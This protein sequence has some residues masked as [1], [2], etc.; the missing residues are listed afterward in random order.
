MKINYK[1]LFPL[2]IF[3]IIALNSTSNSNLR[4]AVLVT[5]FVASIIL[6]LLSLRQDKENAKKKIVVLGTFVLITIMI[7]YFYLNRV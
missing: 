6:F 4:I 1:K 2:Q 3:L 5:L 7:T